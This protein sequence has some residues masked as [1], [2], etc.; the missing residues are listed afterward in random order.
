MA[1]EFP[2][3]HALVCERPERNWPARAPA[4]LPSLCRSQIARR[5]LSWLKP[6]P[7]FLRVRL[8]P[9]AAWAEK[10]ISEPLPSGELRRYRRLPFPSGRKN[11]AGLEPPASDRAVSFRVHRL[12]H[13]SV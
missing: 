4:A 10:Q 8:L 3:S 2:C 6:N 11:S 1:A 13:Q 12:F 7:E 5:L 9:S